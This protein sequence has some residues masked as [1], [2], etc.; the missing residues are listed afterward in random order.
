MPSRKPRQKISRD[1]SI[2]D[3]VQNKDGTHSL[4]TLKKNNTPNIN[5]TV[6]SWAKLFKQKLSK[7]EENSD[8]ENEYISLH[9]EEMNFYDEAP[10]LDRLT[11]SPVHPDIFR[12]IEMMTKQLDLAPLPLYPIPKEIWNAV[13]SGKRLP[14]DFPTEN[15]AY[16]KS[17]DT[18]LNISN[19]MVYLEE[20]TQ[21]RIVETFDTVDIEVFYTGD[22]HI[23]YF[24]NERRMAEISAAIDENMLDQFYLTLHE[25][26]KSPV[27]I[28]P[29]CYEGHIKSNNKEK[30]FIEIN[31]TFIEEFKSLFTKNSFDIHFVLNRTPFQLQHLALDILHDHS[32][33]EV[34]I[35]NAKYDSDENELS[36]ADRQIFLDKSNFNLNSE[37]REAV[38]NIVNATS[39]PLPYVL[40]GPPGTGKTRTLVAAIQQIVQST[41]KNVLICAQSNAACDEIAERLLPV[42][43]EQEMFRLY[44]RSF[45]VH[46]LKTEIVP[47]SNW[48]GSNDTDFCYPPLEFIK[49]FR[50][51]VCTLCT[52]GLLTRAAMP[53]DHFNYVIID[54]C[55]SAH[56][57]MSLIPIIGLC[58]RPGK[59]LAN[60][61]V[62]GDPNQ[63]D[64][65]TKSNEAIKLGY[66]TSFLEHLF[67]RQ[68]Y[69]Y[70][71]ITKQF[72]GKYITQLVRNYRSHHSILKV[73]NELFYKSTL[74]AKASEDATG[75]FINNTILP[76]KNF[77]IIFR[78]VQGIPKISDVN[79]SMFNLKEV[80]IVMDYVK[81]LLK[82]KLNNG[83]CIKQDD[84]GIVTPYKMQR[85]RI[86][87]E[88]DVLHLD[89]I[90]IGTAEVFQGQERPI[91][92]VSTVRSGGNKLGF[93]NNKRRFNVMITRA[94]CLLIVVGDPHLLR[95]DANWKKFI[96]FVLEND[97]LIQSSYRYPQ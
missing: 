35:N 32:L 24:M 20:A 82:M 71:S 9:F 1:A 36:I 10:V 94:K 76:S 69:Q 33:F 47:Y 59:V 87:H 58:T 12:K 83:R 44:A 28:A 30:I 63:L 26:T 73:P 68:L 54:E 43:N 11:E 14:F 5:S 27:E 74:L 86:S 55:A 61:V 18:Y 15:F 79:K 50:V 49:K 17:A 37:Q 92:I 57:T 67:K 78:S 21:T 81:K 84:I 29:R 89:E 56:E 39:Y 52:A 88:C 7:N 64:A 46:K 16:R 91:M 8:K 72:S 6:S 34:L 70:D 4:I 38:R 65:A 42:L 85:R 31:E 96:N 90:T 97:G 77:P 19:T 93:V 66:R 45:G 60:I 13:E 51:V 95:Y 23:F 2:I 22:N 25:K 40:F 48:I 41:D 62:A 53:T 80:D 3:W 75:W